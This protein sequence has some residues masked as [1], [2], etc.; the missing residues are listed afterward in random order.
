M[1]KLLSI[2]TGTNPVLSSTIWGDPMNKICMSL[3]RAEDNL[4]RSL[5]TWEEASDWPERE[6]DTV[7]YKHA[8]APDDGEAKTD[9]AEVLVGSGEEVPGGQLLRGE[10]LRHLVVHYALQT[11]LVEVER[12]TQ[13]KLPHRLGLRA[14]Q[15]PHF[16]LHWAAKSL[17]DTWDTIR[18][19]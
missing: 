15:L 16:L 1:N 12:V 18:K 4:A 5:S 9:V 7:S 17:N 10:A 3:L 14:P 8:E 2:L 11:L 19:R 6:E 13:R